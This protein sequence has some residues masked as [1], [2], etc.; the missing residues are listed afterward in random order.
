MATVEAHT[1]TDTKFS[2]LKN[3]H[4]NLANHW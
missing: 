2:C 1:N 4:K 3:H